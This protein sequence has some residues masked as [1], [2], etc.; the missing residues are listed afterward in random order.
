MGYAKEIKYQL[1]KRIV[2]EQISVEEASL[3]CGASIA[4]IKKWV[5]LYKENPDIAFKKKDIQGGVEKELQGTQGLINVVR[6]Q[7]LMSEKQ[8][9]E[10]A[11]KRYVAKVGHELGTSDIENYADTILKEL[12]FIEL[13]YYKECTGKLLTNA[14]PYYRKNIYGTLDDCYPNAR[15]LID[16]LDEIFYEVKDGKLTEEV[17]TEKVSSKMNPITH[18]ISFSIYQSSK[19][20]AGAAFENHLKKLLDVCKIR[21]KSQQQE[22]EGKTIIDFVI[23]SIEEAQKNPAH[24]A[25][26]E[27]QTTLKDRFRLSSGKTI[28]TDMNCFL[29]TPTGVGIFTKKDNKDITVQ[30]VSE[31]VYEDKMTLVVFPEV[32]ERIKNL[33]CK[34]VELIDKGMDIGKGYLG[35]KDIC[36]VL[37]NQMDTKIITFTQLFKRELPVINK[38]WEIS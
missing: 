6:E 7:F 3:E 17:F 13:D 24:S 8:M 37:L 38:Y 31:I 12:L 9:S 21:N 26:I 33:L 16:D 15:N 11:Y 2:D 35:K 36:E 4:T 5:H 27:C 14:L 29:A 23:P 32:Q 1:C 30:K 20:R 22:R 10:E 28:T 18:L 25:S 34:N 19:S